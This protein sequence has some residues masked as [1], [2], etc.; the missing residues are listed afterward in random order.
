MSEFVG[1]NA[2][3]PPHW[4][5]HSCFC[6]FHSVW[7]HLESFRNMKFS[8]KRREIIQLMQKFVPQSHVVIFRNERT[9][10][11]PLDPKLM[12]S[13]VSYHLGA[14]GTD[15]LPYESWWKTGRTSATYVLRSRVSIFRNEHT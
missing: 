13:C 8:A 7:V 1:T 12:F 5:Q 3:D 15:W 14:I 4:M 6:A 2:P 11:T 9:R 10:S